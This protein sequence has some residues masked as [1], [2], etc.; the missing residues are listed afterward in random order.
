MNIEAITPFLGPVLAVILTSGVVAAF[1]TFIQNRWLENHR[2]QEAERTRLRQSFAE[3]FASYAA[4]K[5]FPYAIRR[6]RYDQESEER[7][8]L[9]AELNAIQSKL[10]YYRAWTQFESPAVGK[11]YADLLSE[12]RKIAGGAMHN[13]WEQPPS[14]NDQ[15]M[16]IPSEKVD[17]RPLSTHEDNYIVAVTARLDELTPRRLRRK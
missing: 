11:A 16:N 13:A 3:A 4:Y 12:M 9:S 10:S 2:S 15:E 14:Q 8:R 1:V 5:E 17:L 7:A 6:R